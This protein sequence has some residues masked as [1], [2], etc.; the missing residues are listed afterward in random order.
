MQTLETEV[1]VVSEALKHV[2]VRTMADGCRVSTEH[3]VDVVVM[4][5]FSHSPTLHR[6]TN[7]GHTR[8]HQFAPIT[9]PPGSATDHGLGWAWFCEL[10]P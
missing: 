5:V 3:L 8:D 6:N 9:P 1:F 4:A 2:D 7:T 10:Y